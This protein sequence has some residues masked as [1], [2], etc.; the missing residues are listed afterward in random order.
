M[1]GRLALLSGL[2]A[3]TAS[4]GGSHA[5][6]TDAAGEVIDAAPGTPDASGPGCPGLAM[7]ATGV[8]SAQH[9]E[10]GGLD[11]T[12]VLSVPAG[13]STAARLPVVF[14]WHGD[15]G[16]GAGIRASF[17]LEAPAAGGAIF[18]Y[19]DGIEIPGDG[20]W[21][22]QGDATG[23]RDIPLFDALL[24]HVEASYCVDAA[25]VFAAGFSR[26]AYFT[27]HLACERGD[28][29]RAI[30][31]H[32]GAGPFW[33]GDAYNGDGQ[34]VCPTAPVPALI[35][36]GNADHTVP[37]DPTAPDGG[38]QSFEHWAYWN[39]PA[40]RGGLDYATDP[41]S[42]SPC[43]AA[44]GLPADHPVVRC[45]IDGL[46]HAIWPQAAATVWAFFSIQ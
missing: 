39:H 41:V 32:S 19:P 44:R 22:L 15:G 8:L 24:D 25:R 43:E 42:P 29:L 7:G 40:P 27:N 35:L 10:V 3:A 34:L 17:G 16:T 33:P 4:C 31:P 36:H 12:Y 46:D 11:R 28:R 30:A 38:W 18:V 14:V 45:F 9:I 1:P 13:A 23:N 5:G 26:G 20:W 37:N 2:V 21:D 6:T